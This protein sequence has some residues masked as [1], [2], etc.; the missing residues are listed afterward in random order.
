MPPQ[1]VPA[2]VVVQYISEAVLDDD[3][4]PGSAPGGRVQACQSAKR[5]W[6]TT[7]ARDLR[8]AAEAEAPPRYLRRFFA[9]PGLSVTL[10]VSVTGR[11]ASG[12]KVT[13]Q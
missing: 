11:L 10:N 13:V 6:T 4:G 12:V 9:C 3:E 5:Y 1:A 2:F 7:K 8:R